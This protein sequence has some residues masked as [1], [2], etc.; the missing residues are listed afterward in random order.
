MSFAKTYSA[1]TVGLGAKIVDVE[2][3]LSKGLHSFMIVGLPDKGVEE[4]RDRV[5]AAIKIRASLLPKAK[6]KKWL[7]RSLRPI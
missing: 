4:S 7:S 1:Q 6:I 3:D 5:S 2:I